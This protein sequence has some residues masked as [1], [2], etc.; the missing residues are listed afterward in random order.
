MA[1][2]D[3][4]WERA[5]GEEPILSPGFQ[6]RG[7]LR[8]PPDTDGKLRFSACGVILGQITKQKRR[9]SAIL[10]RA[11]Y[12]TL[13]MGSGVRPFPTRPTPPKLG[14]SCVWYRWSV[15]IHALVI[16][17]MYHLGNKQTIK[18]LME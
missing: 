4:Q 12:P 8:P 15:L 17:E 18:F 13:A 6:G 7:G 14:C 11:R 5:E 1:L 2:P 9:P 3:S 10:L 16:L